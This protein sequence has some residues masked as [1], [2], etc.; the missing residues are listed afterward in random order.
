MKNITLITLTATAFLFTAC[1]EGESKNHPPYEPTVQT[2]E[3]KSAL[4][5]LAKEAEANYQAKKNSSTH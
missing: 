2:A 4:H 5:K 3:Q 1:I